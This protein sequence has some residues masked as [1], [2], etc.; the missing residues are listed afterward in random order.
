MNNDSFIRKNAGTLE[1]DPRYQQAIQKQYPKPGLT[2]SKRI[3]EELLEERETLL[4]VAKDFALFTAAGVMQSLDD[5]YAY[6]DELKKEI[7]KAKN[8]LREIQGDVVSAKDLDRYHSFGLYGFDHPAQ[9]SVQLSDELKNVRRD[10]GQ[11]VTSKKAASASSGFSFNNSEKQGQKFVNDMVKLMLRAYNAEAENAVKSVKSDKTETAV[12]RLGK[13]KAQVE[14]LGSMINL[15][16][17]PHFHRLRIREIELAFEYHYILR[18]EKERDREIAAE[19]R[20]Q[21]KAEVELKKRQEMLEKEL[22]QKRIALLQLRERQANANEGLSESDLIK[23][24]DL[25]DEV[26]NIEESITMAIDRAANLKAGYVYVISNIGSF[27][28]GRVKIGM[29]RRSDPMDRVKE[30]GDASVPFEFDVHLLHYSEN[31]VDIEKQLHNYFANRR[32]N[33]INKRREHFYASPI[34]VRAAISQL[35]LDGSIT[36]FTENVEAVDFME[37]INIRKE[38]EHS[39]PANR[40]RRA[41]F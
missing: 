26:E 16:I 15:Q 6:Q 36:T 32:V 39:S 35:G 5:G 41:A 28:E 1:E 21:K 14:K 31:A 12:N 11:M 9:N 20:E 30:L 22:K 34:E 23:L 13:C 29:T 40:G 7:E 3:A 17:N 18:L 37:S 25:K 33:M 27:G 8:E 24:D 4:S 19:L 38:L 10:I 2:N